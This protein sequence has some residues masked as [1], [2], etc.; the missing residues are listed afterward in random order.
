MNTFIPRTNSA[1]L[2]WVLSAILICCSTFTDAQS[3]RK[4]Y[5]EMTDS[6]RDALIDGFWTLG[7]PTGNSNQGFFFIDRAD[8]HLAQFNQI[9]FQPSFQ[10]DV[11][12]AWHRQNS[13][14]V[15]QEMQL[16]G[17]LEHASIPYWDWTDEDDDVDNGP[18]GP[19]QVADLWS[20]N[21]LGLFNDAWEL[22]REFNIDVSGLPDQ[23]IH[24]DPIQSLSPFQT[25][26]VQLENSIVHSGGHGW[27][28]GNFGIMGQ[29]NSPKDPVFY[30][31]HNMV[32][33]LW[34]DWEEANPGMS[35]YPMTS[36][37]AIPGPSVDP[38]S[39]VDSRKIGVFYAEDKLAT[40]ENYTVANQVLSNEYFVYQYFIEAGNDFLVPNGNTCEFASC[41][42][43]SL[44]PG[45]ESTLGSVFTA[46]IDG[47]C[48]FS[49]AGKRDLTDTNTG[50]S[51]PALTENI[52]NQVDVSPSFET[53]DGL[54]IESSLKVFPNPLTDQAHIQV[55]SDEKGVG[56]FVLTNILG[57]PI[58]KWEMPLNIGE[59]I[60]EFPTA[61]L[62]KGI[63]YLS[64]RTKHNRMNLKLVIQ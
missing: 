43:I 15:E 20:D 1:W 60:S 27:V 55:N 42:G 4:N 25:Y 14:I 63:Y 36:L 17:G 19:G 6:E 51:D 45:F 32:D 7:G 48:D 10:T 9:H 38:N 26:S 37:P 56:R 3:I 39:I 24:V 50:Q 33:K 12:L 59:N 11:F 53:L 62:A 54:K 57:H 30:F 58:R 44:E 22:G 16:I 47:D 34:Q 2:R 31:H 21:W 18:D 61:N 49:T 28:G 46:R 5:R 35:Q 13:L 41:Q 64:L 8:V 40:L 52:Y 23:V 29:R